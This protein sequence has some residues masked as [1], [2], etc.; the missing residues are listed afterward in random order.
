[1]A[2]ELVAFVEDHSPPSTSIEITLSPTKSFL[3]QKLGYSVTGN[4]RETVPWDSVC[5]AVLLVLC[6]SVAIALDV[7]LLNTVDG[8]GNFMTSSGIVGGNILRGASVWIDHQNSYVF[9]RIEVA[10][11]QAD[12]FHDNLKDWTVTLSALVDAETINASTAVDTGTKHLSALAAAGE[13]AKKEGTKHLSALAAA[14]EE[15]KKEGTKHLSA[16]AAA[17]E[18]AQKEGTKHLSALAAA[19]EEAKINISALVAT[20]DS[21]GRRQLSALAEAGEKGEKHISALLAAAEESKGRH[22]ASLSGAASHWIHLTEHMTQ[23]EVKAHLER[24]KPSL[25]ELNSTLTVV[26]GYTH[27]FVKNL[28][29][30]RHYLH[31]KVQD[32]ERMYDRQMKAWM[33]VL[34]IQAELRAKQKKLSPA[35]T[36]LHNVTDR[37]NS[38]LQEFESFT[39]SFK[40]TVG[41]EDVPDDV[42]RERFQSA[43]HHMFGNDSEQFQDNV[44]TLFKDNL[45]ISWIFVGALGGIR[46]KTDLFLDLDRSLGQALVSL[47]SVL[48]TLD[49]VTGEAKDRRLSSLNP[50]DRSKKAKE[51][52]VQGLHHVSLAT[53]GVTKL[54]LNLTV[55][56]AEK[57]LFGIITHVNHTFHLLERRADEMVS[58]A[59]DVEAYP[60]SFFDH[61][62]GSVFSSAAI[63][64]MF[65]ASVLCILAGLG[66]GWLLHYLSNFEHRM[67]DLVRD[68]PESIKGLCAFHPHVQELDTTAKGSMVRPME[69]A[70]LRVKFMVMYQK[71]IVC[72]VVSFFVLAIGLV[73]FIGWTLLD[74]IIMTAD[75]SVL[76]RVC[77][78]TGCDMLINENTCHQSLA[79][80]SDMLSGAS[81]LPGGNCGDSHLL[82]CSAFFDPMGMMLVVEIA[83]K[84]VNIILLFMLAYHVPVQIWVC[85]SKASQD[86][87]AMRVTTG[88]I[89]GQDAE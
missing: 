60:K 2:Q 13:E 15:A 47:Q 26:R 58:V 4:T 35:M 27:K 64:M 41:M 23:Q 66:S 12:V 67:E 8:F 82:L 72:I 68:Y 22:L 75:V 57:S 36:F 87:V 29:P 38:V 39:T 70:W 81:I 54:L 45:N 42:C 14:G 50:K 84:L 16:L 76:G 88:S 85:F 78:A 86:I 44:A 77:R 5:M 1:M 80:V 53:R 6:S 46:A 25:L 62:A 3:A 34:G 52:I 18:E 43:V 40:Q 69:R 30:L 9:G 89:E 83:M 55:S 59:K 56:G 51:K 31:A 61:Y 17:G 11:D 48:K 24:A 33:K 10:S 74:P 28:V 73:V 32:F 7:A 19:G 21:K 71:I 65:T 63:W 79:R 37:L 20:N 49:D